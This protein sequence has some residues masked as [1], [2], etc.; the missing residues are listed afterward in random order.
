VGGEKWTH[1]AAKIKKGREKLKSWGVMCSIE[2]VERGG[3]DGG[4]GP[5]LRSEQKNMEE[6]GD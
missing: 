5:S 2:G 4:G 3:I 6:E 1:A